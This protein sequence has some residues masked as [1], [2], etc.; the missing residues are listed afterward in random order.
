[1]PECRLTGLGAVKN[2][3]TVAVAWCPRVRETVAD[4]KEEAMNM[5]SRWFA[6]AVLAAGLG[7]GAMTPAPVQAQDSLTR[8]LVDI[9]DV[10]LRSGV[11]YYRYG[12]YG[13]NDRLV[14]SRDRY[15]RVVYYRM[16]PR[17]Y[18]YR[19]SYRSGPPYGNAYGYY[20]N[21]PGSRGMKCNKH[22]KCKVQ[23]YDARYDR[24]RYDRD[25]RHDRDRRWDGR[26][27]RYGD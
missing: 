26:R 16:V 10:V 1:L 7:F 2:P 12:D 13:Y 4:P 3:F 20:R 25:Y 27:W 8:V 17:G 23:Y 21:G 15:G 9:A 11:P 22:G 18:D 5:L 6:P 24:D 14:A 19:S